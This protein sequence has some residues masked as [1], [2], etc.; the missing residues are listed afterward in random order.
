LLKALLRRTLP[1]HALDRLRGL[2]RFDPRRVWLLRRHRRWNRAAGPEEIVLRPGLVL[3]I[4]PGSREP[5]E[6]FCFRS[7]EMVRELD[8]FLAESRGCLRLLDVGACHGLFALAFT[9]G[10]AERSALALE[11]SEV[12]FDILSANAS[13][14]CRPTANGD[15]GGA[16]EPLQVAAGDG[17][18]TVAMRREWHHLKAVAADRNEEGAVLVPLTTLDR[19]CA[20]W[21]FVPDL[22]KIDVEGYEAAV[23]RGAEG[24]LREHRP[25][26]CLEVHPADLASLGESA[27]DLY[28]RLAALGY[29]C[30]DLSGRR[31]SR[32]AFRGGG[33]VFRTLWHS[34]RGRPRW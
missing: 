10:G 17:G 3:R 34:A 20:E 4:A 22:I 16:I 29:G 26:I 25:K 14:N 18:G 21:D 33:A 19:L 28:E 24:L 9:C 2:R 30:T 7:P 13:L 11:P 8:L 27:L 23:L 32:A 15:R 5:F 31:L 6:W 12:A 1:P